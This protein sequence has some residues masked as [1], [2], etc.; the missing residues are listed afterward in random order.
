MGQLAENAS[1]CTE[2]KVCSNKKKIFGWYRSN[3]RFSLGQQKFG[4]A[5][6]KT[7]NSNVRYD[8]G[9]NIGTHV[10]YH[11]WDPTLEIGIVNGVRSVILFIKKIFLYINF[12]F[13]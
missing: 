12:Y 5:K 10:G 3:K 4:L 11:M 8:T 13:L 7:G 6:L 9:S 2:R 1:T